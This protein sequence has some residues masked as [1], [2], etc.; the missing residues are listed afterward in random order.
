MKPVDQT[1]TRLTLG[2]CSRA[3][4]AS[5]FEFPIKEMPNFWESTQDVSE[6]WKMTNEWMKKRFGMICFTVFVNDG[7]EYLLKDVLCIALGKQE[8]NG[9]DH[10][11][12]WRNHLIHDPHPSKAGLLDVPDTFTLFVPVEPLTI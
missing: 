7:H 5:I 12:V 6:F 3:C 11:V 9:E 2:D 10:A 8:R 4:I 1:E